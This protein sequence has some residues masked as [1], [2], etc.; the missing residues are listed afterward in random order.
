MVVDI[1]ENIWAK[2]QNGE[3][4]DFLMVAQDLVL[5]LTSNESLRTDM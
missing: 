4:R 3:H 2:M 5:S 1:E